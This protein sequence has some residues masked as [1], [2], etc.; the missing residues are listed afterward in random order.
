MQIFWGSNLSAIA[1]AREL[2]SGVKPSNVGASLKKNTRDSTEGNAII[3]RHASTR[4]RTRLYVKGYDN[5]KYLKES[6][7]ERILNYD[8]NTRERGS[9]KTYRRAAYRSPTFKRRIL[10]YYIYN[11][12]S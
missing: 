5:D 1:S 4:S 12:E 2:H 10:L 7:I 3:T 9:I 6:S 11:R 8:Y